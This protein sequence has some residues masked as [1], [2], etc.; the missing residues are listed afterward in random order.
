MM[1]LGYLRVVSQ[2]RRS[3]TST[4]PSSPAQFLITNCDTRCWSTPAGYGH[5]LAAT[6]TVTGKPSHY[7]RTSMW[8]VTSEGRLR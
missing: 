1:L 5:R 3:N 6:A 7:S 2:R 8:A 4:R